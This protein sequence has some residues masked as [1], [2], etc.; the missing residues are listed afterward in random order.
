MENI[1]FVGQIENIKD[2]PTKKNAENVQMLLHAVGT[3]SNRPILVD[4]ANALCNV[5]DYT[6]GSKEVISNDRQLE[7]YLDDII[8]ELR[9]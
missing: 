8:L 9:K 3:N 7:K 1:F 5:I 4:L 2:N 6:G